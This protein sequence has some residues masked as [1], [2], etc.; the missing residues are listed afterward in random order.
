MKLTL[1][2]AATRLGKS[3]R[4]V[5]YMIRQGRLS[6][7]KLAG[8]WFIDADAVPPLLNEPQQETQTRKQRQL[9]AA[10]DK[11]LALEP[12][13]QRQGRYSIR[14]LKAFQ[15]ALPAYRTACQ[16]FGPDHPAAR[17]LRQ[18]LEHLSQGCHRFGQEDKAAAYRAARDAASLAVCELA[19][20]E[21]E[22]ADRLLYSL[23][24][25]LMAALAALLD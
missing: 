7:E 12:E 10:V 19:L 15:V 23:E 8:R 20:A 18:V 2:Q 3:Q 9:R 25:D 14:N 4:Q 22:A 6:A 16:E 11:A 21:T 13:D 24:Q 17:L 5:L 1:E